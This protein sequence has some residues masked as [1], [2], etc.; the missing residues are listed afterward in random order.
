MLARLALVC[1]VVGCSKVSPEDAELQKSAKA[2]ADKIQTALVKGD[3]DTV[4]NLTHPKL[5]EMMGG[6]EKM[7]D[8]TAKGLGALKAQGIEIKSVKVLDPLPPV[9]SGKETYI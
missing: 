3:Y 8:L 4:A 2:E 7:L 5:I 6:R 9:K 1:L